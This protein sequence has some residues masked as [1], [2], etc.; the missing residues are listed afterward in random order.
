MQS[1]ERRAVALALVQRLRLRERCVRVDVREGAHVAVHGR[2]AVETGA[3]IGLR[4]ELTL[5][6]QFGGLD[7]SERREF[8]VGH[9]NPHLF[10][11]GTIHDR[12]R[13]MLQIL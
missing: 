9:V 4:G 12:W 1:P 8:G 2:N 13:G 7:G 6:D 10:R 3:D 5:G 11:G